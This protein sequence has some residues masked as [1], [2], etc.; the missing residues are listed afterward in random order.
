MEAMNTEDEMFGF[1]QTAEII[2]QGCQAGLSADALLERVL[3]E[4]RDFSGERDQED[5]QTIVV[6]GVKS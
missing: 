2:R 1:E 6:V 5:D 4:V 3:S